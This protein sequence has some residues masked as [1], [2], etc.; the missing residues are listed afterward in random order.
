MWP[1]LVSRAIGS[2]TVPPSDLKLLQPGGSW[3]RWVRTSGPTPLAR[4]VLCCA[5]PFGQSH[6]QNLFSYAVTHHPIPDEL[7]RPRLRDSG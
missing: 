2:G 5:A 1:S 4:L 7:E 3:G 6:M